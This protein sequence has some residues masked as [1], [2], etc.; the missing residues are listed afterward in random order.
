MEKVKTYFRKLPTTEKI[1][2]ARNI[3]SQMDGNIHFQSPL[4]TLAEIGAAANDLEAAYEAALNRGR[5]ELAWMRRC[6][7][8]LGDLIVALA[9]YVQ[10]VCRGSAT[11]ILSSGFEL[12]QQRAHRVS[13][14]PP[15]GVNCRAGDQEGEIRLS[16]EP[17]QGARAYNIQMSPDGAAW[18]Y[19][20]SST[21]H[22]MI[23]SGLES[24]ARCFFRVAAIG[25][26][27]Q[28]GW[29]DSTVGKAL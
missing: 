19:Y 5:I 20:A 26:R 4:P 24:R 12:Q 7:T 25:A 1:Q 3:V 28:G 27:G 16:W 21:K 29:S 9:A 14:A 11:I 8:V 23:V 2:K 22:K 18:S 13:A 6:D 10:S 17:V 15:P